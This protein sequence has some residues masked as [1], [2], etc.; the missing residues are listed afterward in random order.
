[1]SASATV[2]STTGVASTTAS[3]GALAG[4]HTLTPAMR[5]S[6]RRIAGRHQAFLA[7]RAAISCGTTVNTSPTMP[8]SAMS[9]IGASPSFDRD[10]RLRGLHAGFVLDRARDAESDVQLGRHRHPGLTDLVR[11]R[12]VPGIHGGP[13]GAHSRAEGIGELFDERELLGRAES[14]PS[15][16]PSRAAQLRPRRRRDLGFESGDARRRRARGG[17]LQRHHPRLGDGRGT[18]FDPPGAP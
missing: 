7:S 4:G 13:R 17:D 6:P 12:D 9:K 10:D 16:R 11:V 18:G 5:G 15:R 8:K 2:L 3:A 1:M 14:A